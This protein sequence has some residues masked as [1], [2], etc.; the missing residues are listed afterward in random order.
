MIAAT[1]AALLAVAPARAKEIGRLQTKDGLVLVFRVSPSANLAYQLNCLS[2]NG[3]C[4]KENFRAFWDRQGLS[5]RDRAALDSWGRLHARYD[6][7][8]D[9][10]EE[11][12]SVALPLNGASIDVR[13]KL[14]IAAY[15]ADSWN[16]F[17]GS[18]GLLMSQEDARA[19]LA[20]AGPFH[21][22]FDA[23][24]AREGRASAEDAAEKLMALIEKR[25]LAEL[26]SKVAKFYGYSYPNGTTVEFDIVAQPSRGNGHSSGEQIED[27]SVVE[28][29]PGE[30][31][32][33][34]IDVV[35]HELFHYFYES[36]GTGERRKLINAFA[37]AAEPYSLAAYGLL[38]EA[39]ATALGQGLVSR[40]VMP[41]AD[42]KRYFEGKDTLYAE[43]EV[44]DAAKALVDPVDEALSRGTRLTDASFV[45]EYLRAV[46]AGLGPRLSSPRVWFRSCALVFG[47][48]MNA[49]K[50]RFQELAHSNS[51][52]GYS[53][54]D[55]PRRQLETYSGLSGALFLK[56]DDV[57]DLESWRGIVEPGDLAK[58][59]ELALKGKPFVYGIK[60]SD[61]AYLY[62][63]S[64]PD[65]ASL[66]PLIKSF[67]EAPA[68]FAGTR[69]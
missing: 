25:G 69:P 55:S 20:A 5:A 56:L 52:W 43:S 10:D 37:A 68:M 61:K 3:S 26:Y 32:E 50:D 29:V 13:E 19:T 16:E 14:R 12:D 62:V 31:M 59:K 1:L 54:G 22:R 36:A 67:F 30:D 17:A 63:F 7:Q 28:I 18:L 11:S 2:G 47:L 23:W 58:L 8:M 40:L 15:R 41:P 66:E 51:V 6:K 64:G 45:E 35:S 33:H 60:R 46:S 65:A 48:G 53:F 34:R 21:E 42:F 4:A 57:A 9:L 38:N 39:L 27:H 44:N 49:A 24:W